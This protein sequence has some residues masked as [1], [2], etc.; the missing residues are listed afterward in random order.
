MDLLYQLTVSDLDRVAI[1]QLDRDS[2]FLLFIFRPMRLLVFQAHNVGQLPAVAAPKSQQ[3]ILNK[4]F[5]FSSSTDLRFLGGVVE[6]FIIS[7]QTTGPCQALKPVHL[8]DFSLDC[9]FHYF[10]HFSFQASKLLRVHSGGAF[11]F[12][13]G[14]FHFRYFAL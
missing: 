4:I 10:R 5:R 9:I 8:V 2:I 1:L 7:Y 6:I 3:D 11:H 13:Y 12:C 14:V